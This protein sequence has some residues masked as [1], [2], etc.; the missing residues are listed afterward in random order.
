[1]TQLRLKNLLVML[2]AAII[3]GIVSL[4]GYTLL[5]EKQPKQKVI[6]KDTITK[7][8]S[9]STNNTANDA[10]AK[11]TDYNPS[12]QGGKIPSF[13]FKGVSKKVLP[14]VVHIKTSVKVQPGQGRLPFFDKFPRMRKGSGSGV[15]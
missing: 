15:I 7:K 6:Y 2:I 10:S 1:M 13:N 4:G 3:G 5:A 9:S 11:L 14:T 12:K 8:A